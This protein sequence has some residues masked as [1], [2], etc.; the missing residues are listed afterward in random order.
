MMW[1]LYL[2]HIWLRHWHKYICGNFGNESISLWFDH[3]LDNDL[4]ITSTL[5]LAKMWLYIRLLNMSAHVA[6]DQV[7]MEA[8]RA[9]ETK[10]KNPK[11]VTAYLLHLIRSNYRITKTCLND[12]GWYRYEVWHQDTRKNS[13]PVVNELVLKKLC[14]ADFEKPVT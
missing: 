1:I 3:W 9:T 14:T 13:V 4:D 7:K 6:N 10:Q 11:K 12:Y 2:H 5:H 8:K